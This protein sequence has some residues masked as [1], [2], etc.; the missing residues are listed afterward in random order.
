MDKHN[1]PKIRF[2]KYSETWKPKKL[3]EI[4]DITGGG[5]PSTLISEYWRGNIDWYSPTE[6]G[7]NVYVKG[8][9]KKI[10]D[11]GLENSSAKILPANKTILFTSRAGI[12]DMA[13][14]AKE[15]ATNQGFQSLV[16]KNGFHTYFI[17]SAKP[18]IKK[19]A[20]SKAS[21]S[22]FL[23]I[24]SKVLGNM[25]LLVPNYEEQ[26]KIGD[27][28]EQIDNLIRKHKQKH[29]NL[30]ALKKAM[31]DKMFPKSEQLVPEIRSKRFTGFWDKTELGKI[32]D[33]YSGL[34][35]KTKND[36][37][38]GKAKYVTYMNVFS[39]PIS[40]IN[41]VDNIEIDSSV[42]ARMSVR[43]FP[44]S[45]GFNFSSTLTS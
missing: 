11:L 15:G 5:T 3:S 16:L 10:T 23:E 30:I 25:N 20:L 37:G 7:E 22:T 45:L 43:F 39:N 26:K 12:G 27:F 35:G 21:G 19:Y 9:V 8:S 18:L 38:H 13:I 32:G 42:Y 2:N 4:A 6:I 41:S 29:E 44:R 31:L 34:S 40:D 28:F 33:P 24:S 1:Q 17:F 14:L 36:F